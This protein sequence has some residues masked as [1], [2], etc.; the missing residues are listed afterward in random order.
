MS[1]GRPG[2]TLAAL[3]VSPPERGSFPLDHDGEC[4]VFMKEYLK[5]LKT[6]KNENSK[7]RHL[8]KS[9]LNCRMEHGLMERDEWENFG[10]QDVDAAPKTMAGQSAPTTDASTPGKT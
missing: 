5:C 1:F 10:L 4:K 2:S 6:H 8:S 9:Y 7:C 3:T